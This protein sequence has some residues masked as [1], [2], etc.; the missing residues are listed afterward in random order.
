MHY[1]EPVEE[2]YSFVGTLTNEHSNSAYWKETLNVERHP[3]SFKLD[4]GVEA[5]ILSTELFK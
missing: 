1:D 4:T 3:I 5:D 2:D